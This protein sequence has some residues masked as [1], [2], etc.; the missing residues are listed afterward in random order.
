MKLISNLLIIIFIT[1]QI[2]SKI[3]NVMT[4]RE[5]VW[6]GP[7]ISQ[8]LPK[9]GLKRIW[10]TKINQGIPELPPLTEEFIDG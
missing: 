4:K 5:W 7:Q 2:D 1:N 10:R 3:G 8:K 6:N 9:A